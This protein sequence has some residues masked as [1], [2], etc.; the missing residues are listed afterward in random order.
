[1][2][3]LSALLFAAPAAADARTY[4]GTVGPGATITV[5]RNGVR[6]T[7]VPAGLHTFVIR[8]RSAVHNFHLCFSVF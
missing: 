6:V 1:M 3:T 5:N 4:Y 8:D 2:L 7:R